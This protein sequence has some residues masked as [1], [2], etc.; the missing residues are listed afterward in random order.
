MY[1]HTHIYNA[2]GNSHSRSAAKSVRD[3]R[4]MVF[5]PGQTVIG[6]HLYEVLVSMRCLRCSFRYLSN[7]VTGHRQE[8]ALLSAMR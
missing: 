4:Q 7:C 5:T 3:G 2:L 6:L 8:R 1:K